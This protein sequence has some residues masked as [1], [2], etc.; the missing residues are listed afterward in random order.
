MPLIADAVLFREAVNIGREV[1]WSHTYGKRFVDADADRSKGPPRLAKVFEPTISEEGEIPG[2]EPDVIHYDV[3]T[4]RLHVGKGHFANVTPEMWNYEI[5]GKKVIWQW[6]SYRKR[7]RTKPIIG[8]RRPP[9]PLDKIQP[10]GWLA[11]YTTDLLDL[12]NVLG[13]VIALEPRQADLLNRICD[14]PLIAIQDLQEAGIVAKPEAV[15][16]AEED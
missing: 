14:G 12:L 7:N 9:S 11:E 6:F 5:S 2:T 15:A 4:R 8:D 13:R 3:G 1:I 10:E 16:E